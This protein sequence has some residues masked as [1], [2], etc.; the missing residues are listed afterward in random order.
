[1]VRKEWTTLEPQEKRSLLDAVLCLQRL[2]SI[3]GDLAPGARSRYDDFVATHVNQTT[4]IHGTGNFLSWHRYFAWQYEH[5]LRN[6]CGYQGALP[7]IK[8]PRY[9][10]DLINAPFFDGSDLSFGGNGAPDASNNGTNVP[11][12]AAPNIVIPPGSGGGCITSGPFKHMRV[13]LGSVAP[14]LNDVPKNPRPDGL[15]YNPRCI[16]R[17][18]SQYAAERWSTDQNITD[19]LNESDIG[20]FQTTLQGDF[21]KGFLGAHTSGHFFV[22]GDPGGDLFTSPG[23]PYFFLHHAF[24]DFLWYVWQYQDPQNRVE[25]IA[26]TLTVN[27]SPPSRNATLDDIIELGVNAPGMKIRDAVS[28]L[29]GPFCYIYE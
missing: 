14:A 4:R 18:I 7:Y 2:P 29:K 20:S 6:E 22:G 24:M 5:A 26:G 21:S 13:N 10:F 12:N 9:A 25:V 28:T 23:D 8:E 11:S 3:S 1:M 15:G 27:N 19:L 16:R 17:D